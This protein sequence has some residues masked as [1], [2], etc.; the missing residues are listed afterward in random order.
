MSEQ[1]KKVI[2]APSRMN[3][4]GGCGWR[5]DNMNKKTGPKIL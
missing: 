1:V 5:R 2:T 4:S 3:C